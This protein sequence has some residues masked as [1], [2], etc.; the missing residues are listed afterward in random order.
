[1][2]DKAKT[3]AFTYLPDHTTELYASPKWVRVFFEG[4]R[5][6]DSRGVLLLRSTH[7]TPDYYFP[8]EDVRMD[9]LVD[10]NGTRQVP[11]V[12]EA[13]YYDAQVGERTAERGAW[14]ISE[15][16]EDA[17]DLL[18][19][20]AFDWNAMDAWFEEDEQ[21]FVHPRDPFS[22]ID[23]IHSSRHVRV[24]VE[25]KTVAET[26]RPVLLSETGLPTRAYIP[27]ID[28][29][30]SLLTQSDTITRCP[31]K[32]EA[33]HY[34]ARLGDQ[35][36]QDIAWSYLFPEPDMAKIQNLICFYQERVDEFYVDGELTARPETPWSKR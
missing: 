13:A 8:E 30:M 31:Y 2:T 3:E 33:T 5:M 34:S 29:E 16:A 15:L 36:I 19:Y 18:G 20:I 17:P 27:R 12:G 28:V 14:Q 1:M 26:Q 10:H 6:A 9:L 35:L 32:G 7:G 23:V 24:V 21:V 11:D 4:E 25:G 22:R